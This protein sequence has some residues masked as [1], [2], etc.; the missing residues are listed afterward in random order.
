VT[1]QQGHD[2]AVDTSTRPADL[3]PA[4]YNAFVGGLELAGIELVR[5]H[6]ERAEAGAAAQTRFDMSAGYMRDGGVIHYRYDLTAHFTD[7]RGTALGS[8][9]ASVLI[10][11]H[12]AAADTASIEQFGGTSG[13]LMAHPYLREAIASTALRI[14][15]PGV[16]LPL[17][18]H[19][20]DVADAD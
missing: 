9:A 4:T 10:T 6:G 3:E 14:G 8:A 20:P 19:Q 18:K 15:F 5:V 16:L 1:A 13:A 11:A 17:I 12:T 2:A 7:D